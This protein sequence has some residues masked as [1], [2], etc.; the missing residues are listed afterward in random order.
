M[1]F[2][3]EG[4]NGKLNI[5]TLKMIGQGNTAEIYEF[6]KNKIIKLFREGISKEIAIDE[7]EKAV[8][9][10][11]YINN[12]PHVYDFIENNS[13]Y[14]IIYERINGKDMIMVMIKS[15]VKINYYSRMLAH[16]HMT[17]HKAIVN[18]EGDF[19]VKRKLT[20]DIEAV[21]VITD[22]NKKLL[23]EYLTKLPD[24]DSLCH[25]DF[26]PGNIMIEGKEPVIIDWMTACVGDPC[27]DIARTYIML[28]YGELPHASYFVRKFVSLF[29]RH[30]CKEYYR[31]YIKLSKF[32]EKEIE[33]WM[34][35]VAAARLREWIPDSEK[36]ALLAFINEKIKNLN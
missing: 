9:I 19:T 18:S 31:E 27:A 1:E 5:D 14:G 3:G 7:Y 13:R 33:K 4:E 28:S 24:G 15:I 17:V 26:H 8:F 10:Q 36:K 34:L 20:D 30:I 35:P 11:V 23:I 16:I 29:Q 2:K 25:F 6:E 21:E 32:K 12:A 22:K